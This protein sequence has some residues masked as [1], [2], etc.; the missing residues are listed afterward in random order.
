MK[1]DIICQDSKPLTFILSPASGD[2]VVMTGG[3]HS[4]PAERWGRGDFTLT[5]SPKFSINLYRH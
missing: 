5:S 1:K 4:L 2:C 3:E